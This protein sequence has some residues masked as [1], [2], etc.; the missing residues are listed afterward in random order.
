MLPQN[1]W[2]RLEPLY[3]ELFPESPLPPPELAAVAVAEDNGEIVGFWFMQ[4]CAHMEPAGLDPKYTNTVSLN[5]LRTEL[6]KAF[7]YIP[8][9]EYYTAAVTPKLREAMLAAGFQE[10]GI[11]MVGHVPDPIE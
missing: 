1:E 7:S 9:L 5:Q 4:T 2:K 3:F 10:Y 11:A 8:G 6:H